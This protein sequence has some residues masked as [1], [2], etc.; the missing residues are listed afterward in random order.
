[1]TSF[2]EQSLKGLATIFVQLRVLSAHF[3]IKKTPEDQ[4][5]SGYDSSP[6]SP[7]SAAQTP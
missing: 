7:C 1:M 4:E 5:T 6:T 3:A 2:F